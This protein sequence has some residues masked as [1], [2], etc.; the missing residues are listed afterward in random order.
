MFRRGWIVTN[1]AA[2]STCRSIRI[3]INS[4]T[5]SGS[6]IA[7]NRVGT[8]ASCGITNTRNAGVRSSVGILAASVVASAAIAYARENV[9]FTAISRDSVTV[10][11]TTST[12]QNTRATVASSADSLRVRYV[13]I[14]RARTA[15]CRRT[16]TRFATIGRD[17]I[18]VKPAS[19]AS[20][21]VAASTIA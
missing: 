17:A 9:S 19:G 5:L 18:A 7:A 4:T 14:I 8:S 16:R 15:G 12:L 3:Q 10:R 13:T 21:S 6:I 2:S 1:S 11:K 20:A